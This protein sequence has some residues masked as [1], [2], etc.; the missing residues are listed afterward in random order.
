[1]GSYQRKSSLDVSIARVGAEHADIVV[2]AE[3]NLMGDEFS[4]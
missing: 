3:A 1:V 4:P 2:L